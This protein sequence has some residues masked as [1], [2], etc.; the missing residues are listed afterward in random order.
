MA[1][2]KREFVYGFALLSV[3]ATS[4]SATAQIGYPEQEIHVR[5][6]PSLTARSTHSVDV[7]ATSVEIVFNDNEVCCGK[8]SALEDSIQSADPKSLKNIAERLQGRHLLSDGR[9]IMVDTEF[10]SSNALSAGH[11]IAMIK[12]QHAPLMEWNSHLYV[13]EGVTCVETLDT[14]TDSVSYAI[15]KFL[16]QDVRYSDSRRAIIFDR[17]HDD[18]NQVQGLLFLHVEPH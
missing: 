2:F 12:D 15:H 6:L 4:L 10:L 18:A 13:V 1:S 5:E 14:T 17:L 11:L 16:L 8:D 9:A 3:L 7:L